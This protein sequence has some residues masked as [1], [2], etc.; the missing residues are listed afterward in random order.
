MYGDARQAI[1]PMVEWITQAL[2]EIGQIAISRS[3]D[4]LVEGDVRAMQ[5]EEMLD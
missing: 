1:R 2:H 4:A 5:C 3:D